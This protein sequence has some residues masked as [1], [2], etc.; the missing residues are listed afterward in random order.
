MKLDPQ[1]WMP[2]P[3]SGAA[4]KPVRLHASKGRPFAIAWP[5][6]TVHFRYYQTVYHITLSRAEPL[7]GQTRLTLDG[8]SLPGQTIPLVNDQREHVVN[9]VV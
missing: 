4:S 6:C 1:N 2:L 8:V 7:P 5:R 3:P 9:L